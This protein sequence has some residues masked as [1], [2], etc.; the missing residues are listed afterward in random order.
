MRDIGKNIKA[1][2]A[3]KNMTQDEL[4]EKLFV[5]RQTVSNYETGRSRPDVE[6]L[7]R[8][9]EV[10]E[11]DANALIYGPA[12]A[13][14]KTPL[15]QLALGGAITAALSVI[16]MIA[17]PY[18]NALRAD[19]SIWPAMMIYALLDPLIWLTAGWTLAHMLLLALKKRPLTH[20]CFPFLRRTLIL[21]LVLWLV[22][23]VPYLTA[24]ALDDYLYTEKIRGELA[25]AP[26]ESNGEIVIGKS[27][28][29]IPLPILKYLEPL[30]VPVMQQTFLHRQFYFVPGIMLC[31]LDF[32]KQRKKNTPADK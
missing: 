5:T 15:H 1:L 30:G 8:I 32:P 29:R 28:Q 19:F 2:R 4:A 20:R 13:P 11:T 31:L 27:W 25:D 14:D 7:A 6:M 9:A 17:V 23:L 22:I 16:R 10:L 12:P 3:K 18:A 24:F 26:Y 21:L